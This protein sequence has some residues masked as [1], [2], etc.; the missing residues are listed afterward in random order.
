MGHAQKS[1]R[2]KRLSLIRTDNPNLRFVFRS[3]LTS[4]AT[5]SGGVS[6]DRINHFLHR[7]HTSKPLRFRCKV[8]YKSVHLFHTNHVFITT[9]D[10]HPAGRVHPGNAPV[11]KF[12]ARCIITYL[13]DLI[14]TLPM[15]PIILASLFSADSSNSHRFFLVLH[16]PG[17]GILQRVLREV[18]ASVTISRSSVAKGWSRADSGHTSP[19]KVHPFR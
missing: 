13:Y 12:Y 18:R 11:L 15:A 2:F 17:N 16:R 4:Y 8:H 19:W 9:I 7:Q 10:R 1:S 6:I 14:K 5:F 3:L